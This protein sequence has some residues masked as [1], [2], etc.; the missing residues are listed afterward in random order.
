[1][2][3]GRKAHG[4]DIDAARV[5]R[6][7]HLLRSTRECGIERTDIFFG[8]EAP[9][10]QQR[11]AGGDNQLP[12]GAF[13]RVAERLERAPFRFAVLGELRE[14]MI[15]GS[16]DHAVRGECAALQAVEV[17]ERTALYLC[18]CRDKRRGSCVRARETEHLVPR[19]DQFLNNRRADKTR[20]ASHKN[21]HGNSPEP[22]WTGAILGAYPIR[23]K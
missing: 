1:M 10:R 11:N 2:H 8:R 16:V 3:R 7:R 5:Q 22:K 4:A 21:F 9:W 23:V 17:F 19:L 13:E 20:C 12:V 18:A 15:E 6:G 14:V